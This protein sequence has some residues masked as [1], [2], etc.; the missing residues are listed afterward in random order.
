MGELDHLSS[1]SIDQLISNEDMPSEFT[2]SFEL[3][4]GALARG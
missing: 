2:W 4:S 1:P 3:S